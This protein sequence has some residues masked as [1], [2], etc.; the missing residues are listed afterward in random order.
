M[1]HFNPSPIIEAHTIT[2]EIKNVYGE[3]KAYP[4]CNKAR[5]FA[6]I[7]GTKTLTRATIALAQELGFEIVSI[8]NADWSQVR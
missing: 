3:L 2:V 7:A 5:I 8:A 6:D 4:R 1:Q